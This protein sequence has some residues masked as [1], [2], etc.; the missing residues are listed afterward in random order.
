MSTD[1]DLDSSVTVTEGP[2]TVTKSF[3]PDE[4]PV[5]A[6]KFVI[7]STAPEPVTIRLIDTIPEEFSMESVGFHPDFEKDNWKAYKSHRVEYD[8]TLDTE[9]SVTTVYGVRLGE[10]D[11]RAFLIEP[12]VSFPG[13][14]SANGE[15]GADAIDDVLGENANQVVRDVLSGERDSVPGLDEDGEEADAAAEPASRGSDEPP[16]EDIQ[17]DLPADE[18]EEPDDAATGHPE[19][20]AVDSVDP[21]ADEEPVGG[22]VELTIE[23]AEADRE[24]DAGQDDTGGAETDGME[25]DETDGTGGSSVAAGRVAEA[26]ADEIRSGDVDEADV[27]ALRDALGVDESPEVSSSLDLRIGRLQ[28]KVE[29]LAAYSEGLREFLD[30]EGTAEELIEGFRA[31]LHSTQETLESLS[32]RVDEADED[33][34]R[35]HEDVGGLRDDLSGA[36]DRLDEFE[37][38]LDAATE[39]LST[40][41][42]GFDTVDE[43]VDSVDEQANAVDERVDAVD[44]RIDELDSRATRA[45]ETAERLDDEI[46]EVREELSELDAELEETRGTLEDEVAAV[47]ERVDGELV[48]TR[49][50]LEGDVSAVRE[51]LETLESDLDS[52]DE[53]VEDFRAFRDRLSNALG[54]MAGG[55]A[56]MADTAD[57]D[58]G[59]DTGD[60][61]DTG[62]DEQEADAGDGEE[63]HDE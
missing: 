33:R 43:R 56:G 9:E 11:P 47:D 24:A 29:D 58:T 45:V 40:V 38:R 41:E 12:T 44:D 36:D 34:D 14:E 62:D 50:A 37:D 1:P 15:G 55:A 19:S 10:T 54:T 20:P 26:L 46:G 16:V 25:T 4:F 23:D 30:E 42:D 35:L 21:N 61:A 63:E 59:D 48:E 32:E 7:E 53:T 18:T 8:R 27:A 31:D 17:L 52:L 57:D 3:A 49:E 2:V 39:R 60:D 13:A 22:G 6:I 51:D 5:P 28:T